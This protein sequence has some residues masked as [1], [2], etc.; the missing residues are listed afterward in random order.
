MAFSALSAGVGGTQVVPVDWWGT[1]LAPQWPAEGLQFWPDRQQRK[2]FVNYQCVYLSLSFLMAKLSNSKEA[3][4]S[5]EFRNQIKCEER[6]ADL[7][8]YVLVVFGFGSC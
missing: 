6:L 8:G 5:K 3:S 4:Y 2:N 1:S 7:C